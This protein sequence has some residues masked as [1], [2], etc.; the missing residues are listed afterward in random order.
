[1][2]ALGTDDRAHAAAPAPTAAGAPRPVGTGR[3]VSVGPLA[4]RLHL[5]PALAA[6]GLTAA[7]A[8]V[9]TLALMT[10]D[11]PLTAGEVWR[12]LRGS[13]DGGSAF[14]V[15]TLRL[16]R[17]LTGLLVGA[18]LG[19]S[20]ALLQGL[21]RNVLA[22]PDIIGFTSG[23]A[24]GAI[25]AF[26]LGAGSLVLIG[27][28]AVAGGLLAAVAV[29]TLAH[30]HGN[31]GT[32]LV[33]VG[34]GVT[35]GLTSVNSFLISRAP[36]HDAVAAQAW[37]VGGLN[38][39]GWEHARPVGAALIVLAPLAV[40]VAR[41]LTVLEFGD[42]PAAAL[43]VP[44]ERTRRL[45]L[46]VAVSLAAVATASA[47]P[48]AF[49]ALAAPQLARR[50]AGPARPSPLTAALTGAL[51]LAASDVLT[52]RLFAPTPLPVGILTAGL[53]GLYLTWILAAGWRR[54]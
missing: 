27:A 16:P 49:V 1:M 3:L 35:A 38:N 7:L 11:F 29:Y 37:L 13:G 50:L 40:A 34:I 14:I 39:R 36:L 5:R 45:L 51:L 43:G 22:S 17:L 12:A 2:S 23:A 28:G 32:R 20:G 53:G 48:V 26:V 31:T 9:A 41:R 44:A 21:A 46:A 19:L 47:G 54:P 33:L 4:V 6:A 52:Q 18:A 24:T 25:L 42:D 8:A 10:G 15:T 30:R